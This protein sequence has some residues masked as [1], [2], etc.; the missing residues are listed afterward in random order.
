[1]R[2]LG[3]SWGHEPRGVLSPNLPTFTTQHSWMSCPSQGDTE[4][5]LCC[6][7]HHLPHPSGTDTGLERQIFTLQLCPASVQGG[8]KLKAASITLGQFSSP[9][10]LLHSCDIFHTN[11]KR[12]QSWK[13]KK[14]QHLWQL[15]SGFGSFFFSWSL[16]FS[17]SMGLKPMFPFPKNWSSHLRDSQW[18]HSGNISTWRSLLGD[19]FIYLFILS[20]A[21]HQ[22]QVLFLFW[23]ERILSSIPKGPFGLF[24]FPVICQKSFWWNIL[25]SLTGFPDLHNAVQ[26]EAWETFWKW[27]MLES[28]S[29]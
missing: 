6:S 10:V 3:Y 19:F 11:V 21:W 28:G 16:F 8:H 18:D 22:L 27:T 14:S 29:Y 20:C 12:S 15:T 1:M 17:F 25:P 26:I 4:Q 23:M 5:V 13:K 9:Q 24:F 2:S 7:P